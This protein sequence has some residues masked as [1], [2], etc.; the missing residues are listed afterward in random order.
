MVD[1]ARMAMPTG[2]ELVLSTAEAMRVHPHETPRDG[3]PRFFAMLE[4]RDTGVGMNDDIRARLFEPFFST[5]P[6]GT[7]RGMGLASV[8]GM[9]HQ[10]RGFI[11]CDSIPGE[12]TTLRLFFP[13]TGVPKTPA[14]SMVA[15]VQDA[16]A[17][18]VLLV[19]DDP[20]L[21]DLGK[22][23]LDR[24]VETVYVVASGAEALQFLASRSADVS[25]IITDL[26]MPEMSGLEL[27]AQLEVRY[28]AI[29]IVA[30]SGFT[31]NLDARAELDARQI[32]FVA[33]PFTM[34]DLQRALDKV[35]A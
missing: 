24:L 27:I 34:Q 5:Q 8:H 33:K 6:F 29:P 20:M 4:V 21:R 28:P 14:A 30:V 13:L 16:R 9:V 10:S 25:V 31:V 19:D 12:G 23:M 32:P 7:S 2:G 35:R 11:E 1:N 22:R 17:G 15:V 3:R 26:T 18:G